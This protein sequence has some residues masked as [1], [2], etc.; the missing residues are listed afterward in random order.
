MEFRK[1][2]GYI[3][4]L[5]SG[6]FFVFLMELLIIIC[7]FF[8]DFEAFGLA[9][10]IV[11]LSW[12]FMTALGILASLSAVKSKEGDLSDRIEIDVE[13]I[14]LK[15]KKSRERVIL[16][17]DVAKIE[18][19]LMYR[20]CPIIY[21]TG[22]NGEKIWWYRADKRPE[23]YIFVQHQELKQIFVKR[24]YDFREFP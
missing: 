20:R 1:Y 18:R 17:E 2:G 12:A 3:K 21:V 15:P 11:I 22:L 10:S 7:A 5:L 14:K 6:F 9:F 16:W 13:G 4:D 19:L 23:R 8:G 24:T